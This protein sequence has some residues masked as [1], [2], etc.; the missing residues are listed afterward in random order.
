MVA[1]KIVMIGDSITDSNRLEDPEGMGGGY[2]RLLRDYYITEDPEA[3]VEFVN[4]G[5]SA[6]RI[7]DLE[8]RWQRDVMDEK[9]EWVSISIGINDVWRQLDNQEMDQV[10]PDR[11]LSIYRRLL[12]WTSEETGSNLIL[13]QPTIIEEE[14]FSRGNQML[15]S[16]VEIVNQLAGEFDAILVPAH[17]AFLKHLKKNSKSNLTTDGVHMT[18]TGNMLMAKT[19]IRAVERSII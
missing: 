2:V 7:T 13:M 17:E 16:Y 19:W 3:R 4:K 1:H 8:E 6:N 11:F 18:S 9:P 10:L 12:N 5:V 15:K 14:V